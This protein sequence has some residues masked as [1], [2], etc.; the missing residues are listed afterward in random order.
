M[1]TAPA[2]L[3]AKRRRAGMN[4]TRRLSADFWKFFAAAF[5]FDLGFGLFFFLF[6]LYLTDLHCDE[7]TIGHITACLTLGNVAGTLP[8][9]MLA[10]RFGLRPL[11][12]FTFCTAPLVSVLRVMFLSPSA[13]LALAFAAGLA[14]CCWPICFSPVVASLTSAHNRASGFSI[15]F[16]TGIGMGTCAGILGGFVP[17]F[18]H[19]GKMH[20]SLIGGMRTVLMFAC[21]II[22]VGAWP[23]WK[24]RL[25]DQ[26]SQPQR[27]VRLFHPFLLRFLPPFILWNVVTGS[28]PAFGAIY[29]QQVLRIPLGRLGMVFSASQMVQFFA[30]LAAPLLVRR[31]G[32]IKGIATAQIATSVFL[33]LIGVTNIVSAAV[34]LYLAYN[35]MQ[36]MCSPGIY[37]LLMDRIP[38]EE[39]STASAL[40]NLCGALCQAGTA[41]ISGSC[42]VM[43]GYPPLLVA[44]AA[45]ALVSALLFLAIPRMENRPNSP[46]EPASAAV[47]EHSAE[48]SQS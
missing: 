40:Q 21:A 6:P 10:R 13:Q 35:A 41:A 16:A 17:E 2:A 30:A 4:S 46:A 19:A 12:L 15:V 8:A 5:F 37:H 39:R 32:L 38:E 42:I 3:R 43:F 33:V 9:T 23:L 45:S 14:L 31:R 47:M 25:T 48:C 7:R 28:F 44:N 11:L 24:L 29:L 26:L 27:R 34:V 20:V 18:L 1:S 36:F 22:L